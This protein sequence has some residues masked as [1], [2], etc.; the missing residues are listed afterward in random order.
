MPTKQFGV[1]PGAVQQISPLS[2]PQ[3]DEFPA[4]SFDHRLGTG[5]QLL[6]RTLFEFGSG[7]LTKQRPRKPIPAFRQSC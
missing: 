6:T 3:E 5:E 1:D 2:P 7:S 4:V